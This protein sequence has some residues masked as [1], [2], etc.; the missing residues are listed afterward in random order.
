M[1]GRVRYWLLQ[2]ET[3]I[4]FLALINSKPS[5]LRHNRKKYTRNKIILPSP[6][7]LSRG[8][9]NAAYWVTVGFFFPPKK[10]LQ[11]PNKE[12][13]YFSP[14]LSYH[15]V[16]V[17]PA[18][19]ETL[20]YS[21]QTSLEIFQPR[22]KFKWSLLLAAFSQPLKNVVTDFSLLPPQQGGE[23]QR[24]RRRRRKGER[25]LVTTFCIKKDFLGH[26]V[27][28][29]TQ[30]VFQELLYENIS[31]FVLG[32]GNRLLVFRKMKGKRSIWHKKET[33]NFFC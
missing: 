10:C 30:G 7:L 2:R 12:E 31:A 9:A 20:D 24:R 29:R 21:T 11:L 14:V 32:L 23:N 6:L 25:G 8:S 18:R 28:I 26:L 27:A 13:G 15:D 22:T 19:T 17:S 5:T 4:N 1:H 3:G 16:H 33:T